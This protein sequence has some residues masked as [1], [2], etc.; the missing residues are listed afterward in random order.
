MFSFHKLFPHRS[1]EMEN[2]EKL[3]TTNGTYI[4]KQKN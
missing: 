1:Y 2:W 4:L 3:M